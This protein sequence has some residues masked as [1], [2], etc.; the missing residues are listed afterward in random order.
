MKSKTCRA[1]TLKFQLSERL[2]KRLSQKVKTTV[3][4]FDSV[5]AVT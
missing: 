4:L 5:F 3:V 1:E 2:S